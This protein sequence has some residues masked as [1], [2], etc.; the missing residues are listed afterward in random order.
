MDQI[1]LPEIAVTACH[2]VYENEQREPQPF[3]ISVELALD[4]RPAGR[5][6]A[7]ADT[8]DYGALY[9]RVKA[10]VETT[11]YHLIEALAESIA[12]LALADARV[13]TVKVRV[14]KSAAR[15]GGATFPAIVSVE[16]GR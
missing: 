15:A 11:H 3:V 1:I 9:Q 6:D 13:Q 5:S 12:A 8:L 7:L 10:H 2:G 16:R 4:L 14:K